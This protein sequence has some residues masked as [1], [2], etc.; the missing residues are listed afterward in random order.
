MPKPTSPSRAAKAPRLPLQGRAD[1]SLSSCYQCGKCSV[2]CPVAEVSDVLPH[3]IVRL[4]QL[5]QRHE[6]LRSEHIW[7]C[8]G[9]GTCTARCPNGV[10][11]AELMDHLKAEALQEVVPLGD[12]KIAEFHALFNRSVCKYGRNHELGTLRRLKSVREMLSQLKLGL[13][14]FQRG[15]LRIRPTRIHNRAEIRELFRRAGVGK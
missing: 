10:P 4:V 6:P 15:K 12:A 3:R 8:T 9:C 13:R 5:N 14:L 2:G 1:D 7:Y 11:V